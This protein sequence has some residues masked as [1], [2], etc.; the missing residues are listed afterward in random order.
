MSPA[1]KK[2]EPVVPVTPEQLAARVEKLDR[3]FVGQMDHPEMRVI[4]DAAA[5]LIAQGKIYD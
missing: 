5:E 4:Y 2:E 1:L 3:M